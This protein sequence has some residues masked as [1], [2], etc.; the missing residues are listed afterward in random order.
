[1]VEKKNDKKVT[2][3]VYD[4]KNTNIRAGSAKISRFPYCKRILNGKY[5]MISFLPI[6][7]SK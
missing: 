1:M 5:L 4:T 2:E 7:I 6:I 3:I